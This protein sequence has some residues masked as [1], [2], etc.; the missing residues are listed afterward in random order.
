MK[1]NTL[2]HSQAV[3]ISWH[4]LMVAVIARAVADLKNADPVTAL[5]ALLFLTGDDF[6]LWA[7]AV[8]AP[9]IDEIEFLISGRAHKMGVIRRT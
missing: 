5:D 8:G 6:P 1:V 9:D 4:G 7:E 3:D 2:G